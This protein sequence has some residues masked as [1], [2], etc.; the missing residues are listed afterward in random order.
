MKKEFKT[1]VSGEV[2]AAVIKAATAICLEK[3]I[4][5]GDE[6]KEVVRE[7]MRSQMA[8]VRARLDQKKQETS[9]AEQ[10][11]EMRKSLA[12]GYKNLTD[13]GTVD[14]KGAPALPK[15]MPIIEEDYIK[16]GKLKPGASPKEVR[17]ALLATLKTLGVAVTPPSPAQVLNDK[18]KEVVQEYRKRVAGVFAEIDDPKE[19]DAKVLD[20]KE[21]LGKLDLSNLA[22]PE[23]L[24]ALMAKAVASEGNQRKK[25]I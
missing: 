3:R 23:E 24:R 19:L 7:Q 1:M 16:T 4:I 9:K 15:L 12:I 21:K 17:E 13:D 10:L 5:K 25:E 22:H 6:L 20:F 2:H 14:P 18:E 11:A 8:A